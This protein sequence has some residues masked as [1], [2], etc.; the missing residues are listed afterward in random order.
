M[1]YTEILINIR[2]ILR[3]L[4]LE[5]KKIQKE[6]GVSIPQLMCLDY[7]GHKENFRSTQVEI[8]RFLHLNSSTMSGIV[9]RL[10]SKGFVARLPNPSDK[11]TVF[12]SLTANGARLLEASPQLLHKRLSKKLEK[13]PQQKIMEINNA[14]KILVES[15]E[16]EELPASPII[17]IEDP[18]F[19][20]TEEKAE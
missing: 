3:S 9:N 5:S 2:K 10:E 6:Q 15:L 16:I 19:I 1:E 20:S 7:L 8:A 13:L 17:T 11:R 14:L 4:N 12:I 18:I